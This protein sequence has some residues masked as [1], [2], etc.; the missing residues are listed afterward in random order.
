MLNFA[1]DT[2]VYAA[3]S[4]C[5]YTPPL[6]HLLTFSLNFVSL[7]LV[8]FTDKKKSKFIAVCEFI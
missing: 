6:S 3:S 1:L 5:Y 4:F 7:F 2:L 8:R